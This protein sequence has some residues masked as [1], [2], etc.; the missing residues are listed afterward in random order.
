MYK[1]SGDLTSFDTASTC[2]FSGRLK[3][4][5]GSSLIRCGFSNEWEAKINRKKR[6]VLMPTLFQ[7]H[8]WMK[9]RASWM[10]MICAWPTSP[11]AL[12]LMQVQL[13]YDIKCCPVCKFHR[14][15]LESPREHVRATSCILLSIPLWQRAENHGARGGQAF[16]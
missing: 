4:S 2:I 1:H 10:E 9:E 12:E 15:T 3:R 8:T 6:D 11:H 7:D 13:L 14:W 16:F 5:T